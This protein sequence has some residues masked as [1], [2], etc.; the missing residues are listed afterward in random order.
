MPANKSQI[1][2]WMMIPSVWINYTHRNIYE[3]R[4]SIPLHFWAESYKSYLLDL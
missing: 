4:V 2:E 1:Y 3:E